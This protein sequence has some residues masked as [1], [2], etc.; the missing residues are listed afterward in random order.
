MAM[1]VLK[2]LNL[3]WNPCVLLRGSAE[4]L[5]LGFELALR[6]AAA[7]PLRLPARRVGAVVVR[8][9]DQ[10]LLVRLRVRLGLRLRLS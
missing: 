8:V 5:G 7:G 9:V 4:G 2:T 10:P 1:G 3:Y 6:P